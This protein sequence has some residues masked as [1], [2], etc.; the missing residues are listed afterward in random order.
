MCALIIH[1]RVTWAIG[2]ERLAW[3]LAEVFG[4]TLSDGAITKILARDEAPLLAATAP[5]VAAVRASSV[6]NCD[7]ISA[8]VTGKTW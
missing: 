6:I 4:L 8:Q 5:I 3:L 1:L 2:F 7:E